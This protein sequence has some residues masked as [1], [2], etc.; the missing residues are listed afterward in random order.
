MQSGAL[1]RLPW[2]RRTFAASNIDAAGWLASLAMTAPPVLPD[3]DA[4]VRY[5]ERNGVAA[6]SLA[7]EA[8]QRR[9]HII[10]ATASRFED[11]LEVVQPKLAFVVTCYAQLGHAYALACRRRGILLV[12]LQHDPHEGAHEAY[13]WSSVPE[14]GYR[15]LPALF[16]SWTK[17]DAADIRRW[18]DRL[19]LPWHSAIHGGHTQIAPFLDDAH[20]ATQAWDSKY[21]VARGDRRY[22]RE[23]LV[24]LQPIGGHRATWDALAA[25]IETSPAAWR[26]WIRR[27]PASHPGQDVEFGRLLALRLPN[28]PIDPAS[29]L[30]LPALLRH[31]DAVVSL[32][33]GAGVEA[34]LFG[35]PSL[36]LCEDARAMFPALFAGGSA[37]IVDVAQANAKLSTLGRS[38]GRHSARGAPDIET[39]LTRVERLAESYAQL[40][41]AADDGPI[42]LAS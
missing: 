13:D 9:A 34:A 23:I 4:V 30:P 29:Q 20:P 10:S 42:R 19:A 39:T 24:A 41:R 8:L 22:E 2:Q 32:T 38:S 1:R 18:S 21:R 11:I 14:R 17:R 27:H 16:W 36:F 33:S 26:W 28:V 37:S 3:H 35:V 25:Q 5:L 7:R 6:P 12:D 40:C 31:M 15:T